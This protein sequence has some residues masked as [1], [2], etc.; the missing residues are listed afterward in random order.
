MSET[1]KI[2]SH[3][4]KFSDM[5][6]PIICIGAHIP[7]MFVVTG[8]PTKLVVLGIPTMLVGTGIL[9]HLWEQC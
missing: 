6:V 1:R 4:A 9:S 2:L 5:A 3:S 8:I 7:L